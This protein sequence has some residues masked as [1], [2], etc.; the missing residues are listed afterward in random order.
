[1]KNLQNCKLNKKVYLIR[2]EHVLQNNP[3]S[4]SHSNGS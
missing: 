2:L 3:S 1:M 4:I